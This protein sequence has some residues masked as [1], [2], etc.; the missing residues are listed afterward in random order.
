MKS[1]ILQSISRCICSWLIMPWCSV[2]C[3]V[4]SV[5][6]AVWDEVTHNAKH[7]TLHLQ[8]DDHALKYLSEQTAPLPTR[9]R[10]SAMWCRVA[11]RAPGAGPL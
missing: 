6:C 10:A 5:Q 4:C 7:I 1:G 3:A 2:Q 9:S 8:L 11:S